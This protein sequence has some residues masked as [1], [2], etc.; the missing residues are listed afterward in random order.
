LLSYQRRFG[1]N[2]HS[3]VALSGE[4]CAWESNR[5]DGAV[6]YL[7]VGKTW[8]TA[9]P[10][11]DAADLAAV[12]REFITFAG[13][14]GALPAFVP[15]TSRFVSL[16]GEI[17][18]D[19][20]PVGISPYFDL[21]TW[22]PSGRRAHGLRSG[23]RQATR[24]HVTVEEVAPDAWPVR[25][26]ESVGEAWKASRRA[27]LFGWVFAPDWNFMGYKKLFVARDAGGKLAGFATASPLPARNSFYLEDIQRD[28][29][30]PKGT[31][32]VL[33]A[34]ALNMLREQGAESVT[35]GTVPLAGLDSPDALRR[36]MYPIVSKGLKLLARHGESV[37]NFAGVQIFKSR[38]APSWWEHEYAAAPSGGFL[39]GARVALAAMRAI[40][41]AGI[42]PTVFGL[43]SKAA[44]HETGSAITHE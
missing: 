29:G 38:L 41:P 24:A 19:C 22:K 2:P 42:F 35:L 20:A 26:I 43:G 31:T 9:E 30:A 36:G 10:L 7:P 8:L 34:T 14:S 37:Y 15:V 5:A 18:L 39:T 11:S 16:T 28:P 3:L 33:F 13:E 23:V 17:G 32:D 40:M 21:R 12:T 1:F 25:E 6:A 27:A 44:R 4:A